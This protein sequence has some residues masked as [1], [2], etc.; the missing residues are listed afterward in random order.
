MRELRRFRQLRA[1]TMKNL[2]RQQNNELA[3]LL[4]QSLS[5]PLT[6]QECLEKVTEVVNSFQ[7]KLDEAEMRKQSEDRKPET[8]DALLHLALHH[9][10][11]AN[12]R[13]DANPSN[14]PSKG[15]QN[16]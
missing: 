8:L 6:E 4:A 16:G 3:F 9:G 5:E 10:L 14:K 11:D 7:S 15:N 13:Q 12:P 2:T 1:E